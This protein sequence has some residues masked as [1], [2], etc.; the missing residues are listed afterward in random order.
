MLSVIV[1]LWNVSCQGHGEHRSRGVLR[2]T[3]KWSTCLAAVTG[4]LRY[5]EWTCSPTD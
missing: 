2:R 5:W 4:T 3:R 1:A